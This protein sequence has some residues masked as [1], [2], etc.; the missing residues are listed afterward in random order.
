VAVAQVNQMVSELTEPQTL[1]VEA[2]EVEMMELIMQVEQ[3][4]Q[5]S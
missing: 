2:V 5:V 3:V 1:V 4:V